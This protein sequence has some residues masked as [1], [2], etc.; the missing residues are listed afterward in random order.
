MKKAK[1]LLMGLVMTLL[2]SAC[3]AQDNS[4]LDVWWREIPSHLK[5][6]GFGLSYLAVEKTYEAN[7]S[8]SPEIYMVMERRS[9]SRQLKN[10]ERVFAIQGFFSG[11]QL[12]VKQA[13]FGVENIPEKFRLSDGRWIE[14]VNQVTDDDSW[15]SGGGHDKEVDGP[16]PVPPNRFV[17]ERITAR[18]ILMTYDDPVKKW[19]H[20]SVER[21]W[22]LDQPVLNCDPFYWGLQAFDKD[23]KRLWQHVI[24]AYGKPVLK[25]LGK[26]GKSGADPYCDGC[27]SPGQYEV[28]TS[29]TV[30]PTLRDD[31]LLVYVDDAVFRIR[32]KDGYPARMPS[33]VSI[34]KFANLMRLKEA[35]SDGAFDFGA[36][37]SIGV[38]RYRREIGP[39]IDRNNYFALQDFFFPQLAARRFP[40]VSNK[41]QPEKR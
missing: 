1:L 21:A 23:G 4:Y 8:E 7:P 3:F 32:L 36:T 31:T 35:L 18:G 38:R 41:I 39:N 34:V 11:K 22:A 9:P 26:S 19:V 16:K 25:S 15:P 2:G 37:E 24:A 12:R 20:P 28:V 14:L 13:V 17:V 5:A 6:K 30:G 10:A 29:K 33:N 27:W 40:G